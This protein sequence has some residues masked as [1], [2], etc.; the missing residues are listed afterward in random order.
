MKEKM[1]L[2]V[3]KQNRYLNK[4]LDNLERGVRHIRDSHWERWELDTPFHKEFADELDE[5]LKK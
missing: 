2:D 1:I 5:V 3:F 4:R